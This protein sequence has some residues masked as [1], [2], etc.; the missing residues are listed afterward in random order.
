[1]ST[2]QTSYLILTTQ[3]RRVA[4]GLESVVETM[5]PLPMRTMADASSCVL[6][7][8]LARGQATPVVDLGAV[9]SGAPSASPQRFVAV[10]A[11]ERTV[12]L[13]VDRVIG[14]TSFDASVV[15][16]LPPLLAGADE[17]AV[18]AL[19]TR[20]DELLFVL[21]AGRLVDLAAEVTS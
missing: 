7:V 14:V 8:A 12:L 11:G 19:A 1:L 2:E 16:A 18:A 3:A 13:A 20:D 9:L 10:R 15:R 21:R 6:G 4:I 17:G 5:R